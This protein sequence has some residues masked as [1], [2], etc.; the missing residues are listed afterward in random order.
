MI[1][2]CPHCAAI[3]TMP[4]P[5]ARGSLHCRR[6]TEVLERTTG[7]SLNGALAC[8]LTTLILLFAADTMTILTVRASGGLVAKTHLFSGCVTIWQQ[9][10]PLLAV[11]LA[12]QGVILPY[13][14]FGL[15]AAALLA[16]RAGASGSW[17]GPWVGRGF[18]WAQQLDDWAMPDV[19]LLGAAIGYGRVVAL[20]PVEIDAGGYALI[21]AGFMTMLTRATLDQ[22]AVWRR[23]AAPPLRAEPHAIAC[24][25]CNLV[26]PGRLD[27]GRC[28]RCAAR[29]HRRKPFAVMRAAALIAAGYLLLPVANLFP[30]STLYKFDIAYPHTIFAGIQLLFENG[31]A[32]FGVLIFC[33]SIAFP[34]A[35]LIGMTWCFISIQA[36]SH[37]RLRTKT[38]FFLVIDELGRWSNL[39]PFTLA[40]F[41]PMVQFGQIAHIGVGGGASAFLA[42][43]ITS[44]FAARLFDPRLLWDAAETSPAPAAL[45]AP[46]SLAPSRLA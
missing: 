28:P 8:A 46:P 27:G 16:V 39:D 15:L 37:R 32:P 4:T 3:Q 7:R 40:I 38:R 23:I 11:V 9:G 20:I 5:S 26:L 19:F 44:M 34:L 14:R 13:L 45:S 21:A 10:W 18:R 43:I 1:I 41:V 42:V 30:M 2:A 24:T 35:K 22:Q 33:T 36:G 12:L 31:Y 29:L 25:S 17:S 6:C